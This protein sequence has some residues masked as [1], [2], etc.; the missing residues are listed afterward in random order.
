MHP[1]TMSHGADYQKLIHEQKE[2]AF[3]D[4]P[5]NAIFQKYNLNER[6]QVKFLIV[7]PGILV[8]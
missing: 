2:A 5:N 6:C 3:K 4:M 8:I 1:A 7:G